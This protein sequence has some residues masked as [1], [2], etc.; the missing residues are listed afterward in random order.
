MQ[1][2][3]LNRLYELLQDAVAVDGR[4]QDKGAVALQPRGDDV[5]IHGIDVA[6]LRRGEQSVRTA[7]TYRSYHPLERQDR[8]KDGKERVVRSS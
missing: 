7:P 2:A 3:L 5:D 6:R 1:P 8:K 4:R